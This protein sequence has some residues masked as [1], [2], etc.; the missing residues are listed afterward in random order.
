M[1]PP[2]NDV[3][4]EL[5]EKTQTALLLTEVIHLQTLEE[6]KTLVIIQFLEP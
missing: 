3:S 6:H 1:Q 5:E 2:P 4:L